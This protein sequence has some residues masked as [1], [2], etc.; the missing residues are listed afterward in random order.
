MLDTRHVFLLDVGTKIFLWNG[1]KSNL[2]TRTKSR[3]VI[4]KKKK[5]TTLHGYP[6]IN[7]ILFSSF[8]FYM[9]RQKMK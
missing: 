7:F 1:R 6:G 9:M 5:K 8:F 4:K 2:V 3:L